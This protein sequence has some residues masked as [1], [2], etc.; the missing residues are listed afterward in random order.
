RELTDNIITPAEH[1]RLAD[2]GLAFPLALT[3]TF[4][5]KESAF[6]ASEIQ[7]DA[8][9]LD[10]QIGNYQHQQMNISGPN[11]DHIVQW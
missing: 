4:S 3:L 9:F 10:Y 11:G 1:K 5:A 6:K 8:D 7:T 2:C